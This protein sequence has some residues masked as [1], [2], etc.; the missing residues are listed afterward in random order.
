[1]KGDYGD[2]KPFPVPELL[3]WMGISGIFLPFTGEPLVNLGPGD[4][5]LPFTAAHEAAHLR[6]WAREDEA[7]FL[8]FEVLKDD[9]DPRL[10]YSAWS[11][12]LLYVAQGLSSAGQQGQEAWA[13]VLPR[14]SEGVREDWNASFAY[15]DRFKG[16]VREASRTVNDL[17]LK[18]QG[19]VD[20][21]RS[22]GRMVDLLLATEGASGTAPGPGVPRPGH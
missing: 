21:V 9:P 19:Q 5:Q 10:A 18:S 17:Y 22:Y 15:W 16:P 4:W 3:S 13:R 8:A 12:A 7:N 6:G 11:S 2:P 20:G 1:V 14:V